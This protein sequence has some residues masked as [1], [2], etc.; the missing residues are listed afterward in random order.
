VGRAHP[1]YAVI[2]SPSMIK[3]QWKDEGSGT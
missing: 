3:A 1:T 2:M